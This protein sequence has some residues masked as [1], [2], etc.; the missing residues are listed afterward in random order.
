MKFLKHE[1]NV[2]FEITAL[3]IPDENDSES[4]IHAISEWVIENLGPDA[5]PHF[6]AFH[7]DW[8]MLNHKHAPTETLTRLRNIVLKTGYTMCILGMCMIWKAGL[9]IAVIV[10]AASLYVTGMF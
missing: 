6:T 4:E 8:K 7:P 9:L 3:L 10:E 5:P 1:T 2:W